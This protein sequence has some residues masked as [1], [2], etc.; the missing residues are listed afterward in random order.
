[1][2]LFVG[3]ALLFCFPTDASLPVRAAQGTSAQQEPVAKPA[4]PDQPTA[5]SPQQPAAAPTTPMVPANP[6]AK[7]KKIITNDDLKSGGNGG[8]DFPRQT[9]TQSTIATAPASNKSGS[10]LM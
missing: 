9:S 4:S 3:I 6:T 8:E 1:M 2:L 10:K 7:P 5:E